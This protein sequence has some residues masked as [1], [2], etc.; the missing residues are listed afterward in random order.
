MKVLIGIIALALSVTFAPAFA[1]TTV[2]IL[3]GNIDPTCIQTQC[4]NPQELKIR[5]GDTVI[6][7]NND[8]P[9]HTVVSGNPFEGND[10]EFDSG[11]ILP[12][13]TFEHTF[14]TEGVYEYYCVLHSWAVGTI[15]VTGDPI[16][17]EITDEEVT[18]IDGK[19]KKL[20]LIGQKVGD[21]KSYTMD[22]ISEGNLETSFVNTEENYIMFIFVNPAPKGDNVF[23]KLHE[24]MIVNPNFV[25]INGRSLENFDYTKQGNYNTLSFNAPE[26]VWE[27]KIYG[28]QVVPEFGP[29]AVGILVI[30][31]VSIV[32]IS[33]NKLIKV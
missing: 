7:Q 28:T 5:T 14:T 26:D 13:K 10:G 17:E 12:Q 23:L 33:R 15:L 16:E 22:Y 3:E 25:E 2:E 6:W 18:T 11:L 1:E 20:G 21:G 27:I 19:I 4:Y 32:A 29:L 31:I 30:S 9:A 24:E 8:L